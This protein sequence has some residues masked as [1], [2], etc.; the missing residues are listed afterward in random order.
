MGRYFSDLF[1]GTRSL[2]SGLGVT[3]KAM[4]SPAITVQYPRETIDVSPSFRGHVEFVPTE[5]GGHKCIACR[6]CERACPSECIEVFAEKKEG[7]KKKTLTSFILDFT[8]CSL[9][10]RCCDLCP[11]KAIRYSSNYKLASFSKEDFVMDL[12]KKLEEKN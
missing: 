2:A 9:C 11:T 10:G 6:T 3:F 4:M 12:V 7:E 8:K 1:E 5:A